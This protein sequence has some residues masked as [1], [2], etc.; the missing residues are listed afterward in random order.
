MA[1]HVGKEFAA[2]NAS[3][4]AVFR[5]CFFTQPSH[6]HLGQNRESWT[7]AAMP[8]VSSDDAGV[9]S[10]DSEDI[11]VAFKN[12][13]LFCQSHTAKTE[14]RKKPEAGAPLQLQ[15]QS[16]RDFVRNGEHLDV[17]SKL[18]SLGSQLRCRPHLGLLDGP[19]TWWLHETRQGPDV[20]T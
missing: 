18:E 19:G 6:E 14:R 20:G 12:H 2:S 11:D 7:T 1:G 4:K 9:L 17:V 8:S 15:L 3:S 16:A 5:V 13:G 10:K